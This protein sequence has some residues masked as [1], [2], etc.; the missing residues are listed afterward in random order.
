MV[1]ILFRTAGGRARGKE[2]GLGHV[3]RCLNLSECFTNADKF[4]LVEDYGGVR[5][6]LM[7]RNITNTKFVEPGID[8]KAD[9]NATL[10]IIKKE[11]IDV[12]IVDRFDMKLSYLKTIR[13]HAKTVFISDLGRINFPADLVINGFIGFDNSKTVNKYGSTCLLGP[14]YQ[15][16]NKE[17]S[18]SLSSGNGKYLLATF[19]G[20]DEK[21][22]VALLLKEL[23]KMK[24]RIK[25]KVILGPA[26]RKSKSIK[27][28]AKKYGKNLKLVQKVTNMHKEISG[29]RYGICS[30][31]ITTYEFASQR[32]PFAIICQVKHQLKTAREWERR[33][34]AQNFGL[35]NKRTPEEIGKFLEK[36]S[37][38]KFRMRNGRLHVTG[39][40]AILVS[41]IILE[42]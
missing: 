24:K 27:L 11:K 7:E 12:V 16:L 22:L 15:I 2:L 10:K 34:V 20:F 21:N 8:L 40:G 18:Q 3:Y 1:R 41:K 29:A 17:F 35:V 19:G 9:L 13:R 5:N 26:T 30:G 23:L 25:V 14:R 38:N 6:V 31:G 37:H 39:S 33:G 42:I 36:I 32:V 4:F 28:L